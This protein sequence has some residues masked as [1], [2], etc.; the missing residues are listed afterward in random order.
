MKNRILWAGILALV[1]S[2][3][4]RAA[5]LTLL[6]E[7][8]SGPAVRSIFMLPDGK[9]FTGVD[10]TDVFRWSAAEG[11]SSLGTVPSTFGPL[12][13]SVDFDDVS[14][15][16][17]TFIG[18]IGGFGCL[19]TAST[20]LSV[21]PDSLDGIVRYAVPTAVSSDGSVIVGNARRFPNGL[22]GEQQQIA[23]RWTSTAGTSSLGFSGYPEAISADGSTVVG[24]RSVGELLG[25]AFLWND[26]DGL[27]GLGF[28][29]AHEWNSSAALLVSDNGSV[30]FGFSNLEPPA[31]PSK[32][33]RWTESAGMQQVSPFGESQYPIDVSSDGSAMIGSYRDFDYQRGAIGPPIDYLWTEGDGTRTLGEI[34]VQLGLDDEY[35]LS[36]LNKSHNLNSLSADGRILFGTSTLAV[37]GGTIVDPIPTYSYEHWVLDLSTVPEPSAFVL[38]MV[39]LLFVPH[40][41]RGC[42][43]R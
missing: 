9:T 21:M 30:V 11:R 34:L 27:Q 15:D 5:R 24:M 1:V 18:T 19:W 23:F 20:G 31:S 2:C 26:R 8:F 39:S 25:E 29:A 4:A 22:Y 10:G 36:I 14:N 43:R 7:W 6:P 35:P 37:G 38:A 41:R 3:P 28:L 42:Q 40:Q 12:N 32:L 17:G 33:F 16:G 13:Y